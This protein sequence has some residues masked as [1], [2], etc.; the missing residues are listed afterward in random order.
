MPVQRGVR[1]GDPLSPLLFNLVM[2]Q[3]LGDVQRVWRKRG[4][5]TNVG[6]TIA[7]GRLTHVAFA[8][9]MTLVSRSWLAM[10]RIILT[11]RGAL[12]QRGLA[13]HPSK[14]KVLTNLAGWQRRGDIALEKGLSVEVLDADAN[15][16]LLGTI[17]DL[18]DATGKET[19]NRIAAGWR[20]SWSM[21]PL[22]L[23][24]KVSIRR[25]LRL[26]N[27]TVGSCVMWCLESWT[28]RQEELRKLEVARRAM[29][30]KI[31]CVRRG[32]DEPWVDWIIRAT[33]RATE[34]AEQAGV[35]DWC[36]FHFERK[37]AWA[38][39]V[40]RRASDTWLNKVTIWRDSA[41]QK[42]CNELGYGREKRPSTRRWVKWEDCLR[43]FCTYKC[44]PQWADLAQDRAAWQ[45]HAA[46]FR[47]W[48]VS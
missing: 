42:T 26:L 24:Q 27:A 25:R 10:K 34:W 44:L 9:D 35:R 41:W 29:L 47:T 48:S 11:L 8:D 21:K 37:W 7:G 31:V 23:N 6:A 14:F 30:R 2:K 36:R 15:L 3:V 40:A 13:L 45:Q 18:N 20:M 12:A 33:H 38:G 4:Y 39:H 43:R 32:T 19:D 28:P 5:G 22:L 16:T 17:L 1:Q 46:D